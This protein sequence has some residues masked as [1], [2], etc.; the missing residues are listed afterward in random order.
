MLMVRLTDRAC[1][2][3]GEGPEGLTPVGG[4]LAW[5]IYDLQKRCEG[6]DTPDELWAALG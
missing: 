4:W 6:Y 3:V 5:Q 1:R 2:V